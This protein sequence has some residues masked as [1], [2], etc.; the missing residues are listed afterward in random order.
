MNSSII[1]HVYEGEINH[2]EY[3]KLLKESGYNGPICI[4]APRAGDREWYALQDISYLK[5]II[6]DVSRE[7]IK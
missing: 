5:S 7:Q 3:I 1:M 2:R 4:E 6:A